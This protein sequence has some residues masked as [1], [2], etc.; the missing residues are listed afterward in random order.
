MFNWLAM[1][2]PGARCLDLFCGSGALGLEALSRGASSVVFVDES[3]PALANI[4]QHL[5]TLGG[6]GA[7]ESGFVA[8][9]TTPTFS[10]VSGGVG[11]LI[12]LALVAYGIPELRRYR[13]AGVE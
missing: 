5:D 3:E 13:A 11:A 9:L 1:Q 2:V 7:A 8:A 10:V 6:L 4:R 12:V